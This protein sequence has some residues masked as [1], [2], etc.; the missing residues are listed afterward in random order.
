MRT[1]FDDPNRPVFVIGEVGQAHDGSLGT[2]HAYI[3]AIAGAGA[4][5]VKFQTHIAAAESTPAEP[6]RVA[7]SP[8]DET[9]YDYWKRMEFTPEQWA[10][11]AA[12]ARERGLVFLSTPFSFEAVD[13]LERIEVPAWKVGSG[14]VNNGPFL[15]RLSRM[16]K[17]VLLSS[18]MASWEDLDRAVAL[19]RAGGA[20]LA[21]L[22]CTTAYPCPPDRLGL[23]MLAELRAAYGCV[24]GLSDH[25]GTTHA[26]VAAVALGAE[27]LEVHVTLSRHAFGPDVPASV[28][29]EDFGRLVEGV[30]FVQEAL[31][32]PVDKDASSRETADL[33][34]TFGKSVVLA[35]PLPAGHTLSASDL[36]LKKPGTGIP[37]ARL[38]QLPGRRL[39]RALG[40]DALLTEADLES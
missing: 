3:D 10:G 36:A 31:R 22:Q 14:E 2:A 37:P 40:I 19:V 23:N 17:P 39:R 32:H 18:G 16:G 33:Q 7:F 30:R 6:W 24:V 28:T 12:H 27:V 5:A 4:N 25:S 26:G 1:W 38:D 20:P 21:V 34:R 13:L 29:V 15:E 11:L 8:Q 35:R 9:R